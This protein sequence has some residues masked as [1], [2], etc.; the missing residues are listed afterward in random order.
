MIRFLFLLLSFFHF[1]YSQGQNTRISG[2]LSNQ[3]KQTIQVFHYIE[4]FFDIRAGVDTLKTD[5]SGFFSFEL[6]PETTDAI[7]FSFEQRLYYCF[8]E[9]GKENIVHFPLDQ[10]ENSTII[11]EGLVQADVT[12]PDYPENKLSLNNKIKQ[13][14][15]IF[16]PFHAI[17]VLRYYDPELGR[18]RL[19]SFL[20][21][22]NSYNLIPDK[23]DAYQQWVYNRTGLLE[24]T[25][26]DHNLDSLIHRYLVQQPV[27]FSNPSY[28]ELFRLLTDRYFEY[29]RHKEGFSMVY[30][31]FNRMDPHEF[32][33]WVKSDPLLGRDTIFEVIYLREAYLGYYAGRLSPDM[34]RKKLSGLEGIA[35]NP[36]IGMIADELNE[37]LFKMEPGRPAPWFSLKDQ[38]GQMVTPR[39][40]DT[41]LIYISFCSMYSL[42]CIR[43][44]K[45]LHQL[46]KK[47]KQ[48]LTIIS[49]LD[50]GNRETIRK[51]AKENGYDWHLIPIMDAGKVAEDYNIRD[52]PVY[53]LL[54]GDGMIIRNPAPPPSSD[55]ERTLFSILR[56]MGEV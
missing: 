6:L 56:S 28:R 24:F 16:D 4:P 7:Y 27:N 2:Q 49:F 30:P 9:P 19:D 55:I 22:N 54:D 35:Q 31:E 41:P 29:F 44:L 26:R 8:P 33:D 34:F 50:G 39:S 52:Y 43:E 42:H 25:L 1:L 23:D 12:C 20:K 46:N 45:Y 32:K 36:K 40:K 18:I 10:N 47:H 21:V 17:Q 15:K 51:M 11:S 5:S 48:F 53:L 38:Y 13:F 14:N 3:K 37:R